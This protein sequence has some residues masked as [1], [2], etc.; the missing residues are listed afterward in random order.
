LT[1]DDD[2]QTTVDRLISSRIRWQ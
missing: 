2:T 1:E